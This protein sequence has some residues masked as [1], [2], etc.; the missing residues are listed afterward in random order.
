MYLLL[1]Y[2]N[3]TFSVF[4]SSV[5]MVAIPAHYQLLI[6]FVPSKPV[7]AA[8]NVQCII[9]HCNNRK[10]CKLFILNIR[11][12]LN[13]N[14]W[15][16]LQLKYEWRFSLVAV[17]SDAATLSAPALFIF[18]WPLLNF[19]LHSLLTLVLIS[20]LSIISTSSFCPHATYILVS[21]LPP[22]FLFNLN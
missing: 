8:E 22:T 4:S 15:E 9:L 7:A 12:N 17:S 2:K 16:Y 14:M 6:L 11:H 1:L 10:Y 19:V 13:I 3:F 20:F 18:N 5:V 21:L